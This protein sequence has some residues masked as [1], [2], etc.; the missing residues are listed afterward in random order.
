MKHKQ[1]EYLLPVSDPS[2]IMAAT[3]LILDIGQSSMIPHILSSD[4]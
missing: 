2:A 1:G 4:S 3:I